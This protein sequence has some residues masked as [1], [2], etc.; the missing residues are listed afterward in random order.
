[1][2]KNF[3]KLSLTFLLLIAINF[4]S[5]AQR[6]KRKADKDTQEW[7]YDIECEGIGKRGFK[8]VKVWSYSKKPE[9][10][11]KQAM[12]N[13]VHGLIFKGYSGGANGCSSFKAL[14]GSQKLSED[15]AAFLDTF[16]SDSGDYRQYV[17]MSGDGN[18]APGD[19]L[20]ISK[21]EYKIGVVVNVSTDELR[22]RLESE[23][24][25]KALDAGF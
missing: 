20:K 24:I 22:K 4:N 12:K 13:A 3:I 25:I 11:K 17:T 1:M 2:N 6:H 5:N 8:I 7:R 21:R 16:F 23:G 15:Q 19:R 10:A 14:V 9:F 18:I